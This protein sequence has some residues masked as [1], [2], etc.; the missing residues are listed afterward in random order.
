MTPEEYRNFG[1]YNPNL[2]NSEMT[3]KRYADADKFQSQLR[4]QLK[5]A[6]S[7]I[8]DFDWRKVKVP[9]AA[10][11]RFDEIMKTQGEYK[12]PDRNFAQD[13]EKGM[14]RANVAKAG[15]VL[16]KVAGPAVGIAQAALGYQDFLDKVKAGASY[17]EAA[18][19]PDL[20]KGLAR[21]VLGYAGGNEGGA[22]G[23][24]VPGGIGT[25]AIGTL[26]GSVAGAY[27]GVKLADML[28]GNPTIDKI[29]TEQHKKA[30]NERIQSEEYL[31]SP[32]L[33]DAAPKN[34]ELRDS[35]VEA[36]LRSGDR[37]QVDTALSALDRRDMQ[38]KRRL[39]MYDTMVRA[40]R[41]RARDTALKAIGQ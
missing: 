15:S 20:V 25:K 30:K 39:D 14:M 12:L 29:I 24:M 8:P 19:D 13:F 5:T 11:A 28:T 7:E 21:G 18:T 6:K 10:K 38:E 9:E 4:K 37:D 23:A 1:E 35:E 27:G 2:K 22:V 32:R 26:V 17:K 40:R 16:G 3:A 34:M 41:E 31:K 36:N 33:A